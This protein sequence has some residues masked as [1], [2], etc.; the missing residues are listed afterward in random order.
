MMEPVDKEKRL[1]TE[2]LQSKDVDKAMEFYDKI[3][4]FIIARL[5]MNRVS[6]NS[7]NRMI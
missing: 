3:M 2:N 1:L 7:N 6:V 4:K 5:T